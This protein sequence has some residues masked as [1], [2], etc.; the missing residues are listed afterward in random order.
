MC[1]EFFLALKQNKNV[2]FNL[3]FPISK[4][5]QNLTKTDLF[6]KTNIMA[7]IPLPLFCTVPVV[8]RIW[9]SLGGGGG[10]LAPGP[11]PLG[12]F[13]PPRPEKLSKYSPPLQH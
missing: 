4:P 10:P 6:H 7:N 11:A 2:S 13:C 5:N 9:F 1:D 8:P 12:W 3:K